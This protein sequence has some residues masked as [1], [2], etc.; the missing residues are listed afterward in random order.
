MD[1][2]EKLPEKTS[3]QVS[4][5]VEVEQGRLEETTQDFDNVEEKEYD[6][7]SERSPFPEGPYMTSFLHPL[8][9]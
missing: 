2:N 1:L 8:H 6:Y 4:A 3:A 9:I 7:D 5:D